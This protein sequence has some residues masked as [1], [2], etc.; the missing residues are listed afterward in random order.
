MNHNDFIKL[1]NSYNINSN[2]YGPTIYKNNKELGL[3]IDIK[4]TIFGFLTRVFTFNNIEE[5]EIFLKKYNWYQAN[6]K[7][8]PI[9]LSLDNYE[10]SKPDLKYQYENKELDF[11]DMININKIIESTDNSNNLSNNK[12]I[13]IANIKGITNYIIDLRAKKKEN[14]EFKNK[15]KIEENDLKFI[16]LKELTTYYERKTEPIKKVVTLDFYENFSSDMIVATDNLE[17][18]ELQKLLEDL[19]EKAR[20]EEL[21]EKNLITLY[22]NIVYNYNISILKKQIDFVRNKIEAEKNFNLKGSKIHN[23]DQELKSFLNTSNIPV[24]IDD[25]IKENTNRIQN[26]YN[27]I[28]DIKNA[29]Q[30]ISGNPL[31][32]NKPKNTKQVKTKDAILNELKENYNNLEEN[33]KNSLLLYNSF[34]KRICNFIW[35]NNYPSIE[36][37]KREFDITELYNI[38]KDAIYEVN[39]SHYLVKYFKII[40]FKN[41]DTYLASIINICKTIDNIKMN[42]PEILT[43]FALNTNTKY[44]YFSTV[45]N[46]INEDI[47]YLIKIPKD[48]PILFIPEKV[49]LDENTKDMNLLNDNYIFAK[50]NIIE[51]SESITLNKYKKI[52]ELKKK[53]KKIYTKKLE[54]ITSTQYD[55]CY[56]EGE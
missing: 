43:V 3:C 10:T 53:D 11:S 50:G 35:D 29:Y 36:I 22:S 1:C 46:R 23:I 20:A 45:I 54:L 42:T 8:Y 48:Y 5:T 6:Y 9:S 17:L 12:D 25:F 51:S 7:R 55:I 47:N 30:I 40:D 4:D 15:L 14:F 13:Y 26:K 16:L 31:P 28:L 18:K 44:K 2:G 19:I 38:I 21:E 39:N 33:S 52:N 49:E 32:V 24:K 27:Q 56:I 41:I 34:Y 37:I